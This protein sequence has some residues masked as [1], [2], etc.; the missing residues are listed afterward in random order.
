MFEVVD[1]PEDRDALAQVLAR[2]GVSERAYHLYGAH[3]SD[4]VVMDNRPE[5]W[6]VFYT[7]RGDESSLRVHATEAGACQDLLERVLPIEHA[8]FELVAGPAPAPQAEAEFWAW[9]AAQGLS[10]DGL[11]DVDYKR[12]EVPWASGEPNYLRYFVRIRRRP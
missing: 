5:G 2:E 9:L 12:D 6:V 1:P 10:R 7:E 11:A 3:V 8:R 4:A